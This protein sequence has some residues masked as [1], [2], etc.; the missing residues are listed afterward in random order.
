[1]V[2]PFFGTAEN[3]IYLARAICTAHFDVELFDPP[4]SHSDVFR[5]SPSNRREIWQSATVSSGMRLQDRVMIRV[6]FIRGSEVAVGSHETM[7]QHIYIL[8]LYVVFAHYCFAYFYAVRA[9]ERSIL[10][11]EFLFICDVGSGRI[12]ENGI[13]MLEVGFK[14]SRTNWIILLWKI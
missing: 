2:S 9:R 3:A 6:I 10:N 11:S 14:S 5:N 12:V 1:M 8:W 7:P 4:P 13:L